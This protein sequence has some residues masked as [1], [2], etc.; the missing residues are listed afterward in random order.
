MMN[1]F[2]FKRKVR[3]LRKSV[4]Y[5]LVFII[6][7]SVV[8][9]GGYQIKSLFQKSYH[10]MNDDK[11]TGMKDSKENEN[12]NNNVDKP[13]KEVTS[14]KEIVWKETSEDY[15]K[16]AVFIGDSRLEGFILNNGLLPTVTSY[17]HK[18]LT[19]DTIFTAEVISYN[20]SKISIME[21]LKYTSFS[22]VYLMLGINETGWVYND[23]FIH[24]YEKIIDEIKKI[25]PQSIIYVQSIIPVS[26]E[27][28]NTHSYVK[29]EKIKEYNDL[30]KEMA[31]EKGIYYVNVAEALVNED[32][33]LPEE[34]AFDGIHLNKEYCEKWFAYLKKHVVDEI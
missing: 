26:L 2:K 14:K 31:E 9:F 25:N 7:I 11:K 4:K 18:G 33:L 27:V 1:G 5:S 30:L 6:V 20:G 24:H 16:D 34:A 3:K 21:A 29:N 13:S 28:S 8:F 12:I 10:A 22:K 23:V 19:V 32:G 17:T 15:F